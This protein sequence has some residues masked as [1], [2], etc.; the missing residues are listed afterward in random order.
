MIATTF[1]IALVVLFFWWFERSVMHSLDRA[2]IRVLSARDHASLAINGARR[3]SRLHTERRR[4]SDAA[5]VDHPS[6]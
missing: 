1:L 6:R 4:T 3:L 5:S 2:P